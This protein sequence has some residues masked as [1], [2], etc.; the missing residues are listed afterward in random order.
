MNMGKMLVVGVGQMGKTY[1]KCLVQLGV[2]PEDILAVDIDPARLAEVKEGWPAIRS[3]ASLDE[4]LGNAG[5]SP[6]K[7]SCAFVTVNTPAHHLIIADLCAWGVRWIFTEK[8]LGLNGEA[9][10]FIEARLESARIFTAFLINFSGATEY[11]IDFLKRENLYLAEAFVEWGKDRTGDS[12]PTPGDI[13]DETVHGLGVVNLLAGIN[14]EVRELSVKSSLTFLSYAEPEAQKKAR[15]RDASFP[16]QPNSSSFIIEDLTTSRGRVVIGVHSS[17]IMLRQT[18]RVQLTLSGTDSGIPEY[19][20]WVDFDT[21]E[22]DILSLKKAGRNQETMTVAFKGNKVL[23][24]TEAFLK[25][26]AGGETD[27]RLTDFKT[28]KLSVLLT[29]EII[30]AAK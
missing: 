18:R 17:F 14:Q 25:A 30:V 7:I 10:K 6:E 8:P 5:V 29:D 22:G 13:Q 21:K 16:E 9:V 15:A 26:A 27:P 3:G 19:L 11:L 2:A 24:E 12:R 28:A 20:V 4:A 23:A 1:L